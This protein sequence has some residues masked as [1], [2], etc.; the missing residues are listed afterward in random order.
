MACKSRGAPG[1]LPTQ[2]LGDQ[3]GFNSC[4]T[5]GAGTQCGYCTQSGV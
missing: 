5:F 2:L 4:S 3:G 1:G